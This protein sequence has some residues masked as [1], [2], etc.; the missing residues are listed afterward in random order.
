MYHK[1]EEYTPPKHTYTDP[2]ASTHKTQK[3]VCVRACVRVF[4]CVHTHIESM[5]NARVCQ[6]Y[7]HADV[8]TNAQTDMHALVRMCCFH[9]GP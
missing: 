6:T 1:R 8:N 2:P 7:T 5:N 3:V 9:G 4:V